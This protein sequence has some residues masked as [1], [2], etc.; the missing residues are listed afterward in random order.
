MVNPTIT[1]NPAPQTPDF[2][3]SLLLKPPGLH[4]YPRVCALFATTSA[5][6]PRGLPFCPHLKISAG[7]TAGDYTFLKSA[8]SGDET[9]WVSSLMTDDLKHLFFLGWEHALQGLW[10]TYLS[11]RK[12]FRVCQIKLNT[13]LNPYP[14]EPG[15]ADGATCKAEYVQ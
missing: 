4:L 3:P 6:L 8:S 10:H 15:H 7:N 5:V 11:S 9:K 12:A 1:L 14:S 13:L 2:A